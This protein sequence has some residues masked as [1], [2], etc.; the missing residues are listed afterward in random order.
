MKFLPFFLL[1]FIAVSGFGQE[2]TVKGIVTAYNKFPLKNVTVT[3]KKTKDVAQTNEKGEFELKVAANDMLSFKAEGFRSSNRKVSDSDKPVKVNMVFLGGRKNETIAVGYG[4]ISREN[5]TYGI[6]HYSNENNN[7]T[8]FNN[9]YDLI[10]QNFPGVTIIYEGGQRQFLIRGTKSL[11]GSN[12]A[13]L[14]VDGVVVNDLDFL[15]PY[16]VAN[17]N[18]LKDSSAA[19]Y[20]SRG[21]NGVILIETKRGPALN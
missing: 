4:Y 9:M 13:L 18:I 20:G 21:A 11:M 10:T 7:Y 17:I 12:A 14:V 16:D 19:I 15:S 5:L 6:D 1:M 2:T 8:Q 3:A